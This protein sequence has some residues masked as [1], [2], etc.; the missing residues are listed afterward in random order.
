MGNLIHHRSQMKEFD[1][2]NSIRNN[3]TPGGGSRSLDVKFN[4]KYDTPLMYICTEF[5]SILSK[6]VKYV[7]DKQANRQKVI[8]QLTL[9]NKSKSQKSRSLLTP[10][11]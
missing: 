8:K 9:L 3:L 1:H 7:R 6:P 11:L 2:Y 10:V 4:K 5:G